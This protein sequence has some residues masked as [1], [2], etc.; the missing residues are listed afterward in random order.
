MNSI[1]E[2]AQYFL[3]LIL[4]NIQVAKT[5]EGKEAI[6]N[7]IFCN[8]NIKSN[9][10]EIT[11][12]NKEKGFEYVIYKNEVEDADFQNYLTKHL[13]LEYIKLLSKYKNNI[14]T[15]EEFTGIKKETNPI[16]KK[17]IDQ[18]K[19]ISEQLKLLRSNRNFP[20]VQEYIE[21]IYNEKYTSPYVR[22]L[23]DKYYYNKKDLIRPEKNGIEKMYKMILR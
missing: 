16:V 15:F 1:E 18:K 10:E 9:G 13:A 8:I 14:I 4:D 23:I 5:K 17:I 12:S 20:E 21:V 19:N 2:E 7:A 22:Y 6:D 11:V 3:N